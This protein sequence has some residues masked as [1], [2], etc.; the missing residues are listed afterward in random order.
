M[1]KNSYRTLLKNTLKYNKGSLFI[2]Q[3]NYKY[4][5]MILC[6]S[7]YTYLLLSMSLKLYLAVTGTVNGEGKETMTYRLTVNGRQKY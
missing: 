1:T 4:C 7:V 2:K 5:H 6:H 3:E